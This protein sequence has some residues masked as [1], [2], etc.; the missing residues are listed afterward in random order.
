[1]VANDRFDLFPRGVCEAFRERD[2][3]RDQVPNLSV[4]RGILL[5]YPWPYYFFCNRKD[6]VL[7]ARIERGLKRMRA[8]GS[9][10][11][12][13]WKYNRA[14]IEQARMSERRVIQIPNPL[15]PKDTTGRYRDVVRPEARHAAELTWG[16]R[17]RSPGIPASIRAA[18]SS[19]QC[20]ICDAGSHVI[21][22]TGMGCRQ[23][24]DRAAVPACP[25]GATPGA[26]LP[27]MQSARQRP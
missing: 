26:R 19:M 7:A 24:L 4:E 18:S 5:Y 16:G 25:G 10:N 27:A 13:F 23:S 11:R 1:M 3:R 20:A 15:L 12:I 14:A 2:T 21:P 17:G 6:T 22:S 8:D 9:F